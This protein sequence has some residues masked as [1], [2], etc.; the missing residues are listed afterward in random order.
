[1]YR[2]K[3]S[4]KLLDSRF[5]IAYYMNIPNADVAKW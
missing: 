2:Q 4:T 1:M 5:H 3:K